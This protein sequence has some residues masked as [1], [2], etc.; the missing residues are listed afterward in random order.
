MT[1]Y[2]IG[3]TLFKHVDVSKQKIQRQ[4][5]FEIPPLVDNERIY[6][7][8]VEFHEYYDNGEDE[9]IIFINGDRNSSIIKA[10]ML[11][12]DVPINLSDVMVTMNLKEGFNYPTTSICTDI[13]VNDSVVTV[14]LSPHMVDELGVNTFEFSLTK[15]DVIL[16]SRP[17]KYRIID[18]IGE[19]DIGTDEEMTAL[20][21]LI[22]TVQMMEQ[23]LTFDVTSEDIDDIIGMVDGVL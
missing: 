17:Y 10:K 19:G 2:N 5:I 4:T 16:V 1:Q 11:M 13:D 14:R 8:D 18:S 12:K 15:G 22:Q 9:A 3:D 6:N 21:T 23:D 7:L 20:Q